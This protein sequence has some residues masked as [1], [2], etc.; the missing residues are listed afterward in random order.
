M[1]TPLDGHS[2]TVTRVAFSPPDD[3]YILSVSRDRSWRLYE[4]QGD[5][6]GD[7]IVSYRIGR[8]ETLI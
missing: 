6:A 1:G 5:A 2:L 3:R 4:R 8:G 7:L